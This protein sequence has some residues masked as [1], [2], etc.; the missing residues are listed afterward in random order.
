LLSIL[1]KIEEFNK[2]AGD[3]FNKLNQSQLD[4]LV[5]LCDVNINPD[6]DSI[7]ILINLLDWPKGK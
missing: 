1:D 3:S 5:K 4:S 2:K 6:E 7:K